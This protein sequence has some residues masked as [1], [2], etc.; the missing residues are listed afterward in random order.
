MPLSNRPIIVFGASRGI[1]RAIALDLAARGL[2][3]AVVCRKSTDSEAVSAEI[4]A[5]GGH[6]LPLVADVAR[7]EDAAATVAATLDWAGGLGGIVN[8]AGVIEPIGRLAETDPAAWARLIEV[9]V[10]GAYNGIRAALPHM[11]TGGVIVNISS[12]AGFRP[13]EGWS[14]YCVSKAGLAM[15]TRAVAEEYGPAI[16]CYGF[17]PGVVDTSM[18]VQIR[19]SGLNPVSRI[20]RG[21]LLAPEVPARM[22]GWLVAECP[23]DLAGQEVDV[24]DEAAQARMTGG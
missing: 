17:R 3:V 16:R 6:A 9:N 14:G 8:N 13:L 1:G 21:D 5:T 15:L 2:S 4:A 11:A 24:R 22:V 20:P 23:E 12:G 7:Y 19:A 18:Q 10:T